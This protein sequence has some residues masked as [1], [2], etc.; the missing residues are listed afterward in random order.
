MFDQ[1]R[2]PYTEAL[3]AANPEPDPDAVLNRI[4]LKGEVPSLMRR[5][6]GC[7]FH[8]RCRYEQDICSRVLPEPSTNPDAEH[9]FKCHFPL[10]GPLEHIQLS[11]TNPEND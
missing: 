11:W 8:T 7:E 4:E 1:P 3:L 10:K 6:S 5:P 9:S 2:H